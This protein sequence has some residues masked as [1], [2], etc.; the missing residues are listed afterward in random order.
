MAVAMV[1]VAVIMMFA[2]VAKGGERED[3]MDS[4]NN[5]RASVGVA[6]LVWDEEVESYAVSYAEERR[7]DCALQH[8]NGPYGENIFQG[9]AGKDWMPT[10]AAESWL[11][12][13]VDFNFDDHV[14]DQDKFSLCGH[15]QQIVWKATTKVGCAKVTCDDGGTFITCNYDP[16][17]NVL[18]QVAY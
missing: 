10:D 14:C 17:G 12:E 9:S 1:T 7:A 2:G 13:R 11:S 6:P 15:Y 3:Y 4:Q 18:G 5:E 16:P 8:S